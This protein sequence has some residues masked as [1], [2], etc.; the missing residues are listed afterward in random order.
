MSANLSV[1]TAWRDHW[2]PI[3]DAVYLNTAA[4]GAL[5]TTSYDAVQKALTVKRSPHLSPDAEYFTP[6][7]RLR[8]SLGQLIGAPADEISLNTGASAGLLNVV[9]GL[10]WRRGDEVITAAGEF[11]LQ[12][13]TWKPL[14]QREGIKL[15]IVSPAGPII[16]ADDIVSAIT[17]RTR[18][19]SISH[20]RFDD[21]SRLDAARVAE[22]CRAHGI[23]FVLDIT[24]SCGAIPLDV[25]ALGAD[26]VVCAGY[27]WLL[28]P[29]GTGFMWA[30]REQ[31]DRLRPGPFYWTGQDIG[32]FG[33]LN[34][35]NPTPTHA[36]RRFD[37][38]ETA[39]YFNL[40]LTA[41][42][43]SASFVCQ[44]GAESVFV[45][46]RVLIDTLFAELPKSCT[47][48]SPLDAQQR[49]PYGCFVAET[50]ERTAS[51]HRILREQGVVVSLRSGRIRVSPHLFN[52][53]DHIEQLVD[54]VRSFS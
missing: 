38:A 37:A 41:F 47:P 5:P 46:N 9:H 50:T 23:V 49:G 28:S 21:A 45:H 54:V 19:I 31:L 52:T 12:Y 18:V 24:Q 8:Q 25:Q 17:P 40:N 33:A 34:M 35:V 43:A 13:A 6:S 22:A 48:A 1:H 26:V 27:K 11:P 7:N 42:D 2:A 30:R 29:Y 14:E 20:V 39:S 3:D 44:V 16:T 15:T 32:S 36:A 51:L 10:E 53:E 4:Q